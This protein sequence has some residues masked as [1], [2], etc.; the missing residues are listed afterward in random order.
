MKRANLADRFHKFLLPALHKQSVLPGEPSL[1][2]TAFGPTKE[3][4]TVA[5]AWSISQLTSRITSFGLPPARS[6]ASSPSRPSSARIGPGRRASTSSSFAKHV[7]TVSHIRQKLRALAESGGI[8]TVVGA[9]RDEMVLA[10]RDVQDERVLEPARAKVEARRGSFGD[11]DSKGDL[12][13][14]IREKEALH[15]RSS[16]MCT[17]SRNSGTYGSRFGCQPFRICEN[18]AFS[19]P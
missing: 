8:C 1:V 10:V 9:E 13:L 3:R 12:L 5:P 15:C 17:L 14:F 18:T 2:T 16:E 19:D 11:V 4:H 6:T 7:G